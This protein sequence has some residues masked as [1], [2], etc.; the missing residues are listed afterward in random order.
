M[1][2]GRYDR[3]VLD[4]AVAPGDY[5]PRLLKGTVGE[6][7]RALA[8]WA[9]WVADHHAA[10]G[11]GRTRAAVLATIDRVMARAARAPLTIGTAPEVF[12]VD[13]THIP[14][15]LFMGI[16]DDTTGHGRPWPS[17]SPYWPRPRRADPRPRHRSSRRCSASR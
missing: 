11:L 14:M 1:F 10:Y 3:M 7:D 15:F 2:P 9:A 4:G 17:R 13:D 8:A 12:R 6:N 5:G 16:A